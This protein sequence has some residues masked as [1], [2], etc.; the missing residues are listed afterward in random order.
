MASASTENRP[1]DEFNHELAIKLSRALN[2][3]NP[4]D[5]LATRVTDIAKT[6]TEDGFIKAANSFGKFKDSFLAELYAEISSHVKQEATGHAPQPVQGITVHD[7]EVLDSEVL[8]PEPIRQGGLMRRDTRHAFRKPAKPLEPP[9]PRTSVLGLDR[10]AQEKRAAAAAQ[11]GSRK[12]PRLDDKQP[13]F[14]DIEVKRRPPIP[15][16]CLKPAESVLKSTDG[17]KRNNARELWHGKNL[18]TT[19]PADWATSSA[20]PTAS[21]SLGIATTIETATEIAGVRIIGPAVADGQWPA[22]GPAVFIDRRWPSIL[23][24]GSPSVGGGPGPNHCQCRPSASG[25]S[26]PMLGPT[27]RPVR[28]LCTDNGT[29]FVNEAWR[30][31]CRQKGII[32][33][34]STPYSPSQNGMSE[35]GNHTWTEHAHCMMHN[36]SVP[37]HL[38]A[39]AIATAVYLQNVQPSARHPDKSAWEIIFGH[40]PHVEH[41]RAYGSIAYAKIPDECHTK[42]DGKTVKCM[43]VGYHGRTSYHLYEPNSGRVFVSR[44]VVFDEGIGHW[45]RGHAVDIEGE[46]ASKE[47][48]ADDDDERPN[49]DGKESE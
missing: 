13:V 4:N 44:D 40:R 19:H 29:E 33:E 43:L 26:I 32:H 46:R 49:D 7:S 11:E 16:G 18:E 9:T 23:L 14:K 41:L 34:T 20:V 12:K 39:E 45:S 31:W 35:R 6:N 22:L 28:R 25:E 37:S 27:V 48:S 15:V 38:W 42:L 30:K 3:V 5:L 10:L 2:L 8:E 36:G 17:T 47:P 24:L 21:A 1:T